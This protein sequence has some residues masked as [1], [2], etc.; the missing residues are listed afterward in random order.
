MQRKL[1][2]NRNNELRKILSYYYGSGE[3]VSLLPNDNV[4]Q[5]EKKEKSFLESPAYFKSK[6]RT[7]RIAHQLL[8]IRHYKNLQQPQSCMII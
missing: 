1:E 6:P 2:Y 7:F 5:K 4:Q 8:G 3:S